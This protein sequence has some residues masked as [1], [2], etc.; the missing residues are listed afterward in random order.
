MPL[1]ISKLCP[2]LEHE[3]SSDP[4]QKGYG[5]YKRTGKESKKNSDQRC[6]TSSIGDC[7][8]NWDCSL[9]KRML[10]EI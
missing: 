3:C 7:Y 9:E 10:T 1:Y 2:R 4:C 8:V 5:R 6:D